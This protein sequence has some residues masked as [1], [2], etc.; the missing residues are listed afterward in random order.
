MALA[1]SAR[2]Q[3]P[4]GPPRNR[5]II[6]L[7]S[8]ALERPAV[9]RLSF[10]VPRVRPGDY[11]IGFWRLVN[12]TGALSIVPTG[13]PRICRRRQIGARATTSSCMHKG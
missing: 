11:T 8:L 4:T 10:V 5:R 6:P 2:V 1:R 3:R 13:A 12:M 9:A 7:G